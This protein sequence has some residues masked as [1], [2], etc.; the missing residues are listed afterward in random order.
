LAVGKPETHREAIKLTWIYLQKDDIGDGHEY[1]M[2]TFLGGEPLWS[3]R[4][5][6]QFIAKPHE[7]TPIHS[8]LTLAKLYMQFGAF[9]R[10]EKAIATAMQG[11]PG[12]PWTEMRQADLEAAYGDLYAAWGRM[13]E[14][15]QHYARSAQLYPMAK[16]PYG[17]H[18]LPR[19]AAD[20]QAKLDLLTFRSLGSASLRDGQYRDK[21]LG[22]VGNIDVTV[23][24]R[25]GKIA[26]IQL[27]HEEKIDQNACVLIPERII[28]QQSLQV[29]GIS[30]ATVTKDAI[31]NG[32]YRC[33]KKAGLQ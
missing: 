2:Y 23:E 32:V 9:E 27:Q 8:Y 20:V 3:I 26:D 28:A 25:G 10:A 21:A 12:P 22:Y 5:H 24:I 7:N 31:V 17:G 18:L 30:G 11:L 14:A 33:L 13:D 1:P 6:E 15:K 19:R 29:D 16:P 4:A